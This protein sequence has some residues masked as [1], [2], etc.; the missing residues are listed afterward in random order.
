M[1]H[2]AGIA[3]LQ[4]IAGPVL[5]MLYQVGDGGSAGAHGGECG[6]PRRVQE[7]QGRIGAGHAHREGP[8]VLQDEGRKHCFM[9]DSMH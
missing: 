8:H 7:R 6:V 4:T 1:L 3:G 9:V 5:S 2:I